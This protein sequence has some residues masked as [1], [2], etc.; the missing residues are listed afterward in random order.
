[1][2]SSPSSASGDCSSRASHGPGGSRTDR[3]AAAGLAAPRARLL[4]R[5][6]IAEAF[7]CCRGC[8]GSPHRIGQGRRGIGQTAHLLRPKHPRHRA[9]RRQPPTLRAELTALPLLA[10]HLVTVGNGASS[11]PASSAAVGAPRRFQSSALSVTCHAPAP[12]LD[13]LPPVLRGEVAGH[14]GVSH[15]GGTQ[16]VPR[17]LVVHATGVVLVT[18]HRQVIEVHV[19]IL[20]PRTAPSK[21]L[22]LGGPSGPGDRRLTR[23]PRSSAA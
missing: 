18:N 17:R 13:Q 15:V 6:E 19:P 12:V 4:V 2:A 11:G 21:R 23:G 10:R 20:P 8:G 5:V 9:S 16:E 1:M 14:L 3:R 7:P 22:V